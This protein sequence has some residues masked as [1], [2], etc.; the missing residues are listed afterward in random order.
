MIMTD[1]FS[2]AREAFIK[3]PDLKGRLLLISPNDSGERETN[4]RGQTGTYVYIVT[5]TAVLDGEVSEM[6]DEV[7]MVLEGFQFAGEA[8]TNQLMPALKRFQRNE[9]GAMVLGR[10]DQKDNSF[11]TKTWILMEP[12]DEDKALARK[13]LAD[14]EAAKKAAK[15]VDPFA[16]ADASA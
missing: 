6:V 1:P 12:T 9:P 14:V 13:Y 4:L 15:P 3:M 5:D 2:S 7:P 16:V 11:N 10:L 8:V